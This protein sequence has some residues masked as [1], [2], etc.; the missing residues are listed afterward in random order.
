MSTNGILVNSQQFAAIRNLQDVA[1][2][3]Q[4]VVEHFAIHA[5]RI[6]IPLDKAQEYLDIAERLRTVLAQCRAESVGQR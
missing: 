5:F 1:Q 3:A 2:E 4:H 6:G